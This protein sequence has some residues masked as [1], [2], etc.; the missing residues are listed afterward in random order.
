MP[1]WRG[2]DGG[3]VVVALGGPLLLLAAVYHVVQI[4]RGQA[5]FFSLATAG[6][7]VGSIV[8]LIFLGLLPS[9]LR[10]AA[11]ESACPRCGV[12]AIRKFND[13]K[14]PLFAPPPCGSC[15]AYL[16]L[17]GLMV[18]E[19]RPTATH[20]TPYFAVSAERYLPAVQRDAK[21]HAFFPL[22]HLCAVC[23]APNARAERDIATPRQTDFGVAGTVAKAYVRSQRQGAIKSMGSYSSSGGGHEINL[24]FMRIPVCGQHTLDAAPFERGVLYE[25]ERLS[26]QNYGFYKQFLALNHIDGPAGQLTDQRNGSAT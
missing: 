11:I 25:T 3:D 19:E 5:D 18:S 24:S 7:A 22:P 20:S 1:F 14:D 10:S 6:Y 13:P 15:I 8:A 26:F 17:D 2:I 12:V 21:G 4:V 16:R 9:S 23:G